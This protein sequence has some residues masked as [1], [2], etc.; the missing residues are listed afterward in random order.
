MTI[1]NNNQPLPMPPNPTPTNGG[2]AFMTPPPMQS[3]SP[4]AQPHQQ[5][6]T[7]KLA[8]FAIIWSA[9]FVLS[10]FLGF[11]SWGG[12]IAAT[13]FPALLSGF[14]IYVTRPDGKV[15]G[16]VLAWI[17]VGI[18]CVGFIIGGI[19]VV[20]S[21]MEDKAATATQCQSYSWPNSE[22]G[23][24]L[25]QPESTTGEISSESSDGFSI[26]VCNTNAEQFNSYVSAVQDKGFTV[27]YNKSA[28]SFS[29]KNE[30]GYSVDIYRDYDDDS[31]M[32]ISINAPQEE[33]PQ[34]DQ[35]D[36]ES[37]KKPSDNASSSKTQQSQQTTPQSQSKSQSS[38]F[39]S[40]MDSY[41]KFVDEYVAFMQK[42]EDSGDPVSMLSDY[43]SMLQRYNE[44]NKK[45]D[46]IDEKSL[47]TDDYA[48][49]VE[50]TTRCAQKLA[51]V[52]Q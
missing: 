42:Y 38:D 31:I 33:E 10:G 11:D 15:Q 22:I 8:V 1:P 7:S 16:R 14:S 46:A 24:M 3:P 43:N 13:V 6:K 52:A 34:E 21:S 47:S 41:E 40:T 19:G 37:T 49:Y 39:K 17:A 4:A 51:S 25:P 5:K 45:I 32:S 20:R 35:E 28:D 18:T 23:K 12:L 9:F 26:D 48:Y 2:N 44:F 36:T 29:A 27:D 50:V 30:A